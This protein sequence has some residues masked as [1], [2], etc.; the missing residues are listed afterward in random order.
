MTPTTALLITLAYVAVL[1]GV[2]HWS[3]RRA[4]GSDSE[5]SFFVAGKRAPWFVVAFG[6]VGASLS[7]VT[8][9][10]IPGTVRDQ[11]WTYM[12]MVFGYCI[13]YVIVA[14]VLLPLYYKLKLTSIYGYLG[15]RFG[16][17]AHMTGAAFFLLSRVIGASFRLFLVALVIDVLILE[18]VYGGATPWTWFGLTT[19]GILAVIYLYTRRS[20]MATVIWTD[21]LQTACMLLAVFL[22][23]VGI[24]AAGGHSWLDL[25]EVVTSTD[26]TKVWVTEDWKLGNY[27]VKDILAGM[28]ITIAMT[29]LDQDMMQKIWHVEIFESPNGIWEPSR[30][31][32]LWPTSCFS[33]WVRYFGCM[34]AK[35]AWK[36]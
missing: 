29:G 36:S 16:R 4:S 13:G 33:P 30:S 35:L 9:L 25:P 2:S 28:F 1:L 27:W 22:T 8:F 21:T 18:P 14:T 6:M 15:E 23:V 12:Q 3:S 34:P 26:L 5:S 19:A 31:F 17:S 24:L 10:S 20:G 7:G 32:S 11:E